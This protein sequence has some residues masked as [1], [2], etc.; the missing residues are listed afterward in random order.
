MPVPYRK[1][2]RAALEGVAAFV[3]V[4][5]AR[6]ARQIVGALL[7]ID[8]RGQ[9]L[10][11]VHNVVDVPGGFLWP[12]DKVK[13]VGTAVLVHSLFDAC[14]RE[15]DLLVCRDTLGTPDFCRDELAPAIPFAQIVAGDEATPAAW[16]WIND[17][18][19]PGMRAHLLYEH[20]ARRGFIEEPFARLQDGL[21]IAYPHAFQ[22][23]GKAGDAPDTGRSSVRPSVRTRGEE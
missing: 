9:P 1:L 13:S 18:P 23:R 4:V 17:P 14:Q 22:T 6:T 10:E 20:L 15:P 12:E 5:R 11:F 3:D 7:L 2:P 16:G 21:R 19:A 8:G